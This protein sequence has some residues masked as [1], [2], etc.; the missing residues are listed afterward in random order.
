MTCNMNGDIR[1]AFKI[2]IIVPA[3]K[4]MLDSYV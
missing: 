2:L 4:A 3:E 1:N